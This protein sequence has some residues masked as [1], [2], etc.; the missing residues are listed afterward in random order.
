MASPSSQV[1]RRRQG[2]V[3]SLGWRLIAWVL[4]AL[5]VVWAGSVVFAYQAGI[6]EADELTDGHLASA[7]ALMLSLRDPGFVDSEQTAA[8]V[9]VP[10]LKSHDYQQSLNAIL[11]SADG[12][13][14][15]H[16]GEAPLMPFNTQEGF[17]DV[18]LGTPPEAWR[19]FSQWDA[20][21]HRKVTVLLRLEERDDLAEDISGQIAWPGLVLLPVVAL[22]LVLVI[23]RGLRP[24]F[25]LSQDVTELNAGQSGRLPARQPFREFTSVVQSINALMDSQE[26]ALERER[27]LANEVA[28]ELR[29]PLAS[30]VLQAKSLQSPLEP[31][32]HRRAVQR[33]EQD[34][35]KAGHVLNQLLTLARA[36][37]TELVH[38]AEPVELQALAQAVVGDFAQTAWSG[39]RELGLSGPGDLWVH[40]HPQLIALALRNLI[41]NALRYTPEGAIVEVQTGV[42]AKSIWLQVCDRPDDTNSHW[43]PPPKP[44]DSLGLGH[45]I[46]GRIAD[47]HGGRFDRVPGG[48][49]EETA[50]LSQWRSCYRLTFFKTP[51]IAAG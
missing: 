35:L 21:R 10:G 23:W 25:R 33:I 20:D 26:A 5:M 49:I 2:R 19:A 45:K 46:V 40:G 13:L 43:A 18:M 28:H 1:E 34:A 51:V 41:E 17:T 7:A 6:H 37:R 38:M 14:L 27:Q 24:L 9:H 15:G 30:L 16:T 42:D 3:P 8:R 29:T 11:W 44:V 47:V 22:V 50:E 4:G 48:A 32:D 12:Q 36:S 31:A 39:G